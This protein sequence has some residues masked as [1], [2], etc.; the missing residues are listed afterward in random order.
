MNDGFCQ[1]CV[2]CRCTDRLELT[3]GQFRQLGQSDTLA[4]SRKRLKTHLFH[5]CVM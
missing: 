2:L 3:A 1:P 4:T 5:C